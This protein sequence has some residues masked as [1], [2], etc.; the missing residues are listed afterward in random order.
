MV[1]VD[2]TPA[3][4]EALRQLL[5]DAPLRQRLQD[6]ARQAAATLPRWTDT[7][8]LVANKLKEVA[9]S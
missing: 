8:A 3:L 9:R 7:A 6:G 5:S 2:D 1:P 4:A